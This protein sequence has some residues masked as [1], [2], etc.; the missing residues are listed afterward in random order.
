MGEVYE[1]EDLELRQM[2]ALKTVH[3]HEATHEVAIER[4]K[5]EIYLARKVTHANVCRIYDVGYH[6]RPDGTSVI[7]LTM[8]L[9]AGETLS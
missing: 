2:V 8:E 6:A 9:L 7:Y 5:R 3:S 1:A 4:F